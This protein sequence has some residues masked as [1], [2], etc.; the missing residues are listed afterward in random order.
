MKDMASLLRS[1]AVRAV[2]SLLIVVLLGVLFPAGGTFFR[3][4]THRDMLRQ[5]SVNGILACGMTIVIVTAGIDLSVGSVLGLTAVLFA[6]LTIHM[7]V[8]PFVAILGCLVIGAACGLLSGSVI[9]RFNAAMARSRFS[10]FS[11]MLRSGRLRYSHITR[12]R[13]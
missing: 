8:S 1:P 3:W 2:A 4:D 5:V 12:P 7:G 9:A 6:L 11:S 10:F 13:R